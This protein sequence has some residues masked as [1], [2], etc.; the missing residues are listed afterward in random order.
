MA[1][2]F[3]VSSPLPFFS[4]KEKKWIKQ[5]GTNKNDIKHK[6]TKQNLDDDANERLFPARQNKKKERSRKRGEDGGK[7]EQK[8]ED[9]RAVLQSRRN[10]RRRSLAVPAVRGGGRGSRH[11]FPNDKGSSAIQPPSF[12]ALP[13]NPNLASPSL[14]RS[15]RRVAG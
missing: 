1:A 8:V 10:L 5:S 2:R 6:S 9:I 4:K 11:P 3:E 13:H 15:A 14:V 7:G 12:H